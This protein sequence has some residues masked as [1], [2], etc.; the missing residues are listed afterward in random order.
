MDEQ[1]SELPGPAIRKRLSQIART[2]EALA[3]QIEQIELELDHQENPAWGQNE[4]LRRHAQ[5]TEQERFARMRE[6]GELITGPELQELR[7]VGRSA[8]AEAYKAGR[9]FRVKVGKTHLFPRFFGE[10][11]ADPKD[12]ERVCKAL[13]DLPGAVKLHFF[14]TARPSLGG[15]TPLD[16]LAA[17]KSDLAERAARAEA[18]L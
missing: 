4:P 5:K 10:H 3:D 17:G 16:A 14:R 9:I 18:D 13:G 6:A 2:L 11:T 8:I 7:G 1:V 12:L 15:M